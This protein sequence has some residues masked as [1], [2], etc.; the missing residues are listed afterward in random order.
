M[1]ALNAEL[2]N[3]KKAFN[4]V[5]QWHTG[6]VREMVRDAAKCL[7]VK[8]DNPDDKRDA[9]TNAFLAANETLGKAAPDN[10]AAA[11]AL[12]DIGDAVRVSMTKMLP[13]PPGKRR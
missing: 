3:L 12:S 4:A 2:G 6:E 8:S 13:Q 1:A 9:V 7:S 11:G 10:L 5:A